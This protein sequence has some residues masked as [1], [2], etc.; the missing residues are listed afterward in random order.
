MPKTPPDGD[1]DGHGYDDRFRRRQTQ[2]QPADRPGWA[3]KSVAQFYAQDATLSDG[4]TVDGGRVDG[5]YTR[6]YDVSVA[7]TPLS[8]SAFCEIT[9]ESEHISLTSKSYRL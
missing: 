8:F 9:V 3:D 4:L 1:P 7:A 2:Y 5:V 6:S